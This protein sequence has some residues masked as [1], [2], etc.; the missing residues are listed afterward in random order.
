VKLKSFLTNVGQPNN[1]H[2]TIR[3]LQ[4]WK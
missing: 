3:S 4:R 1:G 2:I